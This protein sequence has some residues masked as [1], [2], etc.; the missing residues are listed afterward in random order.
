MANALIIRGMVG[1]YNR[2]DV[3][4][5]AAE[6]A[7]MQKRPAHFW[8]MITLPDDHPIIKPP[9]AVATVAPVAAK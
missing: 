4:T 1:K 6:M 7:A 5:D 9:V 3:V 8:Q 2:G